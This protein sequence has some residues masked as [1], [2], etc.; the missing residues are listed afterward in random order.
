[1]ARAGGLAGGAKKAVGYE[2]KLSYRHSAW[3][4]GGHRTGA[5]AIDDDGKLQIQGSDSQA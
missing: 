4:D 5:A 3:F 2:L 1:V